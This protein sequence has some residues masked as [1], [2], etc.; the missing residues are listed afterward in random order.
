MIPG[1]ELRTL[2]TYFAV[3]KLAKGKHVLHVVK[4]ADK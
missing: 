4:E 3:P 1:L 2:K